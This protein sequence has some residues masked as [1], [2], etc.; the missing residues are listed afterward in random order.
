[1]LSQINLFAFYFLFSFFICILYLAMEKKRKRDEEVAACARAHASARTEDQ[2]A[3]LGSHFSLK[4]LLK[5]EDM[6]KSFCTRLRQHGWTIIEL[7]DGAS[8]GAEV[9]QQASEA[10]ERFFLQA[11]QEQKEA[12]R[13]LFSE[14]PCSTGKG[15]VGYNDPTPAKEVYRLRRGSA[16]PWPAFGTRRVFMCAVCGVRWRVGEAWLMVL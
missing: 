4:A 9:V 8:S 3:G 2:H 5:C 12:A 15:L 7:D 13:L 10:A 11:T 14:G 16:Q 1:L 6:R